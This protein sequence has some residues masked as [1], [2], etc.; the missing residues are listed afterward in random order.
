MKIVVLDGFTLNPGDLS[1]GGLQLLG[2]V[3]VYDRTAKEDIVSRIGDADAILTNKTP[4]TA[5]T[6]AACPSVKYIGVL[7]T[8]YNV[9]DIAAAKER[10]SVVTVRIDGP[11]EKRRERALER[12]PGYEEWFETWERQE[13]EHFAERAVEADLTWEWN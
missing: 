4:I 3:T 9:V 10:G 13:K 8:G 1:W 2:S 6:L 5:E 12:D 11:R 7:A